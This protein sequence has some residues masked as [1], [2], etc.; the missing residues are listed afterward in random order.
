MSDKVWYRTEHLTIT[1]LGGLAHI[2]ETVFQQPISGV[3]QDGAWITI[4][5][6][7]DFPPIMARTGRLVLYPRFGPQRHCLIAYGLAISRKLSRLSRDED[8]LSLADCL[9]ERN[10]RPIQNGRQPMEDAGRCEAAEF[11]L[12][13]D[14]LDYTAAS[15]NNRH[16]CSQPRSR[17]VE[18]AI[19]SN[20]TLLSGPH[21]R[22]RN[23]VVKVGFRPATVGR[24]Q[25]E[26]RAPSDK[27]HLGKWCR[28]DCRL[29]P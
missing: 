11:Q 12:R 9:H 2:E 24:C 20:V 1:S 28:R 7:V 3:S 25:L 18:I 26:N 23:K 21:R 4:K 10:A 29:D 17:A 14:L 15:E 5:P 8:G 19:A 27:S 13:R 16:R 6:E 22:C